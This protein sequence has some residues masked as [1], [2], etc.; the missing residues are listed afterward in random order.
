[1]SS[2]TKVREDM[3]TSEEETSKPRTSRGGK[4]KTRDA[5]TEPPKKR[6][7]SKCYTLRKE[8]PAPKPAKVD[9]ENEFKE[10]APKVSPKKEETEEELVSVAIV[11][12]E[13][14]PEKK[15]FQTNVFL[16]CTTS[17]EI[18]GA[19]RKR[20][21][22]F[23][24]VRVGSDDKKETRDM[25]QTAREIVYQKVWMS[26]EQKG[27]KLKPPSKVKDTGLS[28]SF[29]SLVI[30]ELSDAWVYTVLDNSETFKP[31]ERIIPI[32]EEEHH[33]RPKGARNKGYYMFDFGIFVYPGEGFVVFPA[34]D[35]EDANDRAKKFVAQH[36]AAHTGSKTQIKDHFFRKIVEVTDLVDKHDPIVLDMDSY[37][38][39]VGLEKPIKTIDCI[40]CK[41]K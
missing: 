28:I 26:G 41:E 19:R 3:E 22:Q 15:P 17:L 31:D 29:D 40:I 24:I 38:S 18:L 5:S 36:L 35:A 12:E 34:W 11:P 32:P 9:E 25:M 20:A 14:K 8:E 39:L 2:K 7:G 23:N 16:V 27:S 13:T 10:P 21:V 30:A 6:S 33:S 1:M 37:T 4:R